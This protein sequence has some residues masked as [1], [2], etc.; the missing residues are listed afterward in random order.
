[1][2]LLSN[3]VKYGKQNDV[4]VRL[5]GNGSEAILEVVD[6]GIGIPRDKHGIIFNRFE[7]VSEETRVSGL[8]LGLYITKEI[9][10][11]H[12]G[13]I[14][15]KSEIGKGSTFTLVLPRHQTS[16]RFESP[17]AGS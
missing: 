2:N 1:V 4:H 17:Q 7:R 8:G 14:Q 16:E 3:A 12:G 13:S 9:V 15:V 11:A 10:V 5:R 6:Q